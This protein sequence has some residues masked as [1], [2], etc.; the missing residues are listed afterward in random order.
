MKVL[1]IQHSSGSGGSPMSLFYL[2]E[3]LS[4]KIDPVVVF[5]SSGPSSEFFKSEGYTLEISNQLPLFPHCTIQ[6]MRLNPL[7]RDFY[8]NLNF[9]MKQLLKIPRAFAAMKKLIESHKPD[10]IHLNSSVLLIEGIMAK[11]LGVPVVWHL[12]DFIEYG[13][14]GLRSRIAGNIIRNNSKR[15]IALC[16]S[17]A[18]RVGES[19]KLRVIPNFVEPG[20]FEKSLGDAEQLRQRIGIVEDKKLIG[21]LGWITPDKGAEVII[22]AM[23]LIL[24]EHP[25]AV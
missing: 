6:H 11:R 20:Y 15:I 25:N 22:R 2:L 4:D 8:R 18:K 19:D 7:D 10:I 1:T 14:F 5:C 23:P 9:Y 24:K 17:E 12:R 21:M 3:S 13:N 16:E